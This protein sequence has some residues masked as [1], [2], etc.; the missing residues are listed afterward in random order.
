MSK[1]RLSA[2]SL[3]KL[4]GVHPDLQRVIHRAIA[5]T[6]IDFKVIEGLRSVER[7]RELVKRGAS[8]TMNSRHLSGHAVDIVPLEDTNRDGKISSAEMWAWP[9]YYKLAKV[10]KQAAR[11]VGVKLQWGGDWV[12]FKDGPHWQ[13]PWKHYP[14]DKPWPSDVVTAPRSEGK[15]EQRAAVEESAAIGTV[16]LGASGPIAAEPLTKVTEAISGQQ[17]ELSSGDL[18]RI[19]IAVVIVGVTVYV[20]WPK[21]RKAAGW[22]P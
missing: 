9:A 14:V 18:V 11:D 1:Y 10:I 22:D 6:D 16:G 8:K 7:Q 15:T 4:E 17:Y 20:T 21:I 13:L 2:S 12:K 19:V 5:I 3:A